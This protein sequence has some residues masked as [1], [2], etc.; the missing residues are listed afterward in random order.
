MLAHRK[1]DAVAD[2]LIFLAAF[3]LSETYE[4]YTTAARLED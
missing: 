1:G 4:M 2:P 3:S